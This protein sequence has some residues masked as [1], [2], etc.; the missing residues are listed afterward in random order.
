MKNKQGLMTYL[1]DGNIPIDN[2]LAERG[3]KPFVINRK[4]FLF[5][6][7]EKGAQASGI[8]MSIIQTA[9]TCGLDTNKYLEYLF[10]N[11]YKINLNESDFK[12][13]EI[14]E[15]K[16]KSME[17]LLPWH[18]KIKEQFKMKEASR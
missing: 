5:S 14:L 11:L 4:N 9:K 3:I 13:K 17:H 10:E 18:D 6:N 16:F 12:D 8:Y 1:N 7:T 15:A 2:N